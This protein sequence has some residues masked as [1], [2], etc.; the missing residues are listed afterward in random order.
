MGEGRAGERVEGRLG[1]VG[2]G[3]EGDGEGVEGRGRRRGREG[4]DAAPMLGLT[5]QS[6]SSILVRDVVLRDVN[7]A[8]RPRLVDVDVLVLCGLLRDVD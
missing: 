8:V 1:R 2:A 5:L 7:V 6:V 4:G 3:A